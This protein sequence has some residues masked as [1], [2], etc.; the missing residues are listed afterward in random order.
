MSRKTA[1]QIVENVVSDMERE[2]NLM[3]STI[4]TTLSDDEVDY[5][6]I[7]AVNTVNPTSTESEMKTSTET[8]NVS[9]IASRF[10]LDELM[11]KYEKKSVVIRFLNKEGYTTAEIAR[12]MNIRYQHV[13]NT[14]VQALVK[15]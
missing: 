10:S 6:E 5:D 7:I 1:A 14:L 9:G 11:E 3:N 8:S 15:K 12:F 2:E 4:I 13:R